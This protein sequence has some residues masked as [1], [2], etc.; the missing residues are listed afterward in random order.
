MK[1]NGSYT[2][3]YA[4]AMKD[5]F[6]LLIQ[7]EKNVVEVSKL[8]SAMNVCIRAR[9]DFQRSETPESEALAR[10]SMDRADT[11]LST[12]MR[13]WCLLEGERDIIRSLVRSS[14]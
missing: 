14:V 3:G 8:F 6:G 1:E 11:E 9:R 10:W 2:L 4:V 5:L 12:L 13:A 7:R